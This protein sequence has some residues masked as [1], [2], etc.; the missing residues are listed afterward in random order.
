M[1]H[2]SRYIA[3][4]FI[5][6][7]FS[8][9]L[10]ATSYADSLLKP[11]TK[12]IALKRAGDPTVAQQRLVTIDA[13]ILASAI[14]DPANDQ[15]SDRVGRSLRLPGAVEID[16]FSGR[17][18]ALTRSGVSASPEG[19]VMWNATGPGS[20]YAAFSIVN[21][22]IA[23]VIEAAGRT[24]LID[25]AGPGQHV[26]KELNTA[27]FKRDIH[28]D[29]PRLRSNDPPLAATI[30][31]RAATYVDVLFAYTARAKTELTSGG[32]TVTQQFDRDLAI[33]NRGM[34]N[35]GV[36][37]VLRRKGIRAISSTYSE[38]TA[39][40]V[41][42]LFDLTSGGNANFPSIRSARTTVRADLVAMYIKRTNIAY[43]GVAWL[44][45][46]NPSPDY[47]FAV[48]EASFAGSVT[49]A[50]ELGHTMGL[51]HDRYVED[52]ASSSVYNY[53]FVSVAGNFRD[54]MSY[55]DK[56]YVQKGSDCPVMTYFSNPSKTF[57][58]RAAGIPKGM[59]GAADGA[60]WLREKR[61]IIAGF[62]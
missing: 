44:N 9:A 4:A 12:T 39:D 16:L 25:P 26:L 8:I 32:A 2:L 37:I 17:S 42:P 59:S 23:G 41:K 7:C 60:R 15:D 29:R 46:P 28:V 21:G 52:R 6:G 20:D 55:S 34:V 35:S 10:A 49:L 53:G 43:R 30:D 22:T 14:H 13:G 3:F 62:R 5:L 18:V 33:V 36:P 47:A 11:S 40:P 51:F 45:E 58:A 57:N 24:Y 27:G 38:N 61:G 1:Q 50:H 48:V 54:I 19:G 56:C 31:P